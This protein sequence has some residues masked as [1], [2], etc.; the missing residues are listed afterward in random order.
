MEK[1]SKA[2]ET[3]ALLFRRNGVPNTMI[4][5]GS[6][7][8][9]QGDFKK[10]C[11]EVDCRLKQLEPASQWGNTAESCTR[12]LQ[13]ESAQNMLKKKMPK[14]LWDHCLEL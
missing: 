14:V 9:T 12:E 10:K 6:M 2:P 4:V 7:E 5:D 13:R 1:T 11:R 3:L 8:Q